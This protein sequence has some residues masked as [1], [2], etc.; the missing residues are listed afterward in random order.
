MRLFIDLDRDKTTGWEGYDFVVNRVNP[1]DSATVEKSTNSWNWQ[2]TGSAE[3]VVNGKTL[4]IKIKRSLLGI[5]TSTPI[6]LEF[7]WSDN[8]QEDGNIMDFYVNGDVAPGGRFNYIYNETLISGLREVCPL[9]L[10]VSPNPSTKEF[11]IKAPVQLS[12][13]VVYDLKGQAVDRI[14]LGSSAYQVRFGSGLRPGIYVVLVST[15]EGLRQKVK[16]IKH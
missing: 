3:Y 4:V 2:K 5:T 14:E 11:L 12:S 13:I 8:M 1:G 6:N 16:I 10:T 7:K 15:K 9:T